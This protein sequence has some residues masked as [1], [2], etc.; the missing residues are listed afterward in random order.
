MTYATLARKPILT[1]DISFSVPDQVKN[2]N[3]VVVYWRVLDTPIAQETENVMVKALSQ[4]SP[5]TSI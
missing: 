4:E 5:N 2:T 1:M 3:K